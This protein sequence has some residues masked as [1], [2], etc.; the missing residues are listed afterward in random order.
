MLFLLRNEN[1][2]TN[3]SEYDFVWTLTEDGHMIQ[4]GTQVVDVAPQTT[5]EDY[6]SDRSGRSKT[7]LCCII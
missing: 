7:R 6:R 4:E 3:M 2:F 5:G 1:L